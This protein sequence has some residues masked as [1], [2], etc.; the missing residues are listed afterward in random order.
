MEKKD[1]Q[2]LLE[3]ATELP[4]E[5]Q[6]EIMQFM[7]DTEARYYGVYVTDKDE[8]AALERSQDDVING[9]FAADDHVRKVL[10]F[11]HRA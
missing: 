5:A 10:R 8:R 6:N 2:K 4:D 1:F 3:R 9:R 7:L 11:F